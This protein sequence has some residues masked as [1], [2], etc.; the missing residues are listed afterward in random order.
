MKKKRKEKKKEGRK[1]NLPISGR[2]STLLSP[3][4]RVLVGSDRVGAGMES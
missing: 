1:P 2:N 4:R 3:K